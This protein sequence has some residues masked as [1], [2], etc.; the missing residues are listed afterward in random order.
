VNLS[1][2]FNVPNSP[3]YQGTGAKIIGEEMVRAA[4]A[5][6]LMLEGA[7]LPL[8]PINMGMLR[9]AWQ[10]KVTLTGDPASGA[11]LGRVFNP[12]GYALPV[13]TGARPHF[14]PVG[15]LVLWAR[16]KFSLDEKEAKAIG[17]LV[18]RAIARRG[19]RAVEMAKLALAQVRGRVE[20]RFADA[21]SRAK[22]RIAG[23]G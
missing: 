22:N 20:Q 4:E 23:N 17:F 9:K 21:F 1:V 18:A 5:G 3:L 10:T 12:L 8:T 13:E 19:T 2:E 6:V 11:V 14:P 15:P 16:R 7:V